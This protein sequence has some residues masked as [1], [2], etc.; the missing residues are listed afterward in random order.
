[1]TYLVHDLK[2]GAFE[3]ITML[4]QIMYIV[5]PLT[6]YQVGAKSL[7]THQLMYQV[8]NGIKDY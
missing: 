2:N 6:T 1:M 7:S 3:P 4:L 5:R 8:S